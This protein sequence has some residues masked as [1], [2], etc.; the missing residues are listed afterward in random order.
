[1]TSPATK[2][3]YTARISFSHSIVVAFQSSDVQC[4]LNTVRR[5][6]TG[7]GGGDEVQNTN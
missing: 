2:V 6:P 7:N 1:M 5:K 4:K 3:G